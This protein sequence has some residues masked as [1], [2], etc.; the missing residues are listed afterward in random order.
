LA[1][2]ATLILSQN[3]KKHCAMSPVLALSSLFELA[4]PQKS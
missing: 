2:E 1:I 4:L 3:R